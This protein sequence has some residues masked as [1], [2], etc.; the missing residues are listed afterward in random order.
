MPELRSA[1]V[2]V[3]VCQASTQALDA[4]VTPGYGARSLRT[5]PDETL[6]V[7]QTGTGGDVVREVTDRIAA[8]DA[9][10]LV[11]DVTDGWAG[12]ALDGADARRAFSYLSPLRLPEG[13]GWIQGEVVH[14]PAK[15]LVA[16]DEVLILVPSYWRDHVRE[17]AQHDARATEVHA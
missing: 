8:L 3:V 7:T 15:V 12:W 4:L 11:L 1:A 2:D 9:D 14:V 16:G 5:A 10:A 17:R 13:D 6:F